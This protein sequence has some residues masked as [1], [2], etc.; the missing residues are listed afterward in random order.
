MEKELNLELIESRE[1]KLDKVKI[2]LKKQFIGI[3]DIIDK[4]IDSV[5]LWYIIPEIQSRPLIVNLWGITGVGKTDLVRKFVKAIEFTDKFTEIQMDSKDGTATIEDYLENTFE[6]GETQGILLLDEM[7]RFR[8]IKNDGSDSSSSK[9]QD[10]WMLLSDGTFQ[11]NAK[12]KQELL[13][14]ILE[15]DYYTERGYDDDD[16]DDEIPELENSSSKKKKKL[17]PKKYSTSYWEASNMKRLLK[18]S[19]PMGEIMKWDKLER[20]KIIKERLSSNETY[21]GKK[22]TK[23]LIIISGNLDEAFTM[24]DNVGDADRDADV[25]HEY[26]KSI[27]I[28]SIKSALRNRFKPEQIARL[29]NIHLI[30][31]IPSKKAYYGII[32]QKINGIIEKVKSN[33]NIDFSVDQSILDVIYNNGVFPTQ[34]VRPV[35]ST[36]SSIIENSLPNFLYEMLKSKVKQK[37]ELT[38]SD[39]LI[40]SI[41]GGKEVTYPIP[42]VLDDIKDKQSLDNKALVSVHEAGH[43]IVYAILFKT[44]PTQIV[45]TTSDDNYDGFVGTHPLMGSKEQVLNDISVAFGG[46]VAES[47]IFGD[48][49]ISRGASGDIDYAT[50]IASDYVRSYGFDMDNEISPLGSVIPVQVNKGR[51]LINTQKTDD[52]VDEILRNQ[53]KIVEGII[54]NNIDFLLTVAN[55]LM[56]KTMLSQSEFQKIYKD[57]FNETIPILNAGETIDVNYHE[58][59]SKKLGGLK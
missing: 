16:E 47:I 37:I 10:L 32:E 3:D 7:Q 21:E 53:Y 30:Y 54:D 22:Y 4:F 40:K 25:Y 45:A 50:N 44:I 26:S 1:R 19:E 49:I 36:V 20:M 18:L 58:I 38:Y 56:V 2:I 52:R 41:I 24:A 48:E 51:Y 27:D 13:R 28:I 43:A 35:L 55:E 59:L 34:G 11:S 42:T 29:G 46:R 15:D 17:G 31:P 5:R 23:L 33:N 6:S 12:I 8:T 39:G 57:F 9:F 14:M